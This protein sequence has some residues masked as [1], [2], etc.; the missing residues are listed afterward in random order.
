[1]AA[2]LLFI[3]GLVL[4]STWPKLRVNE[5]LKVRKVVMGVLR[6][7]DD[8]YDKGRWVARGSHKGKGKGRGGVEV[9]RDDDVGGF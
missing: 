2:A 1:M 9:V 4:A 6:D 5:F 3:K 8:E 7:I